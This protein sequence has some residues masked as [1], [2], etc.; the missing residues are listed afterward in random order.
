VVA[1]Q[2]VSIAIPASLVS[3]VPHLRE[4]TAKIGTIG[5]AAGIFGVEEII[6]YP[7]ANFDRQ[8]CEISLIVM[9][10]SYLETPQ[11]LRKRLFKIKPELR[12]VGVLP[13][14]RSQHH[15]LASHLKDLKDGEIRDGVVTSTRKNG[16]FVDVGVKQHAFI[17]H[18]RLPIGRRVTV[19]LKKG[20]GRLEGMVMKRKEIPVHWGYRVKPSKLMLGKLLRDPNFDLVIGTSRLG[21][22]IQNIYSELEKRWRG[23]RR[24]LVV[25]GGP[26]H[27]LYNIAKREKMNLESIAD[28]IINVFP[29][30]KVETVR[31]EEAVLA[32]LGVLNLL[33]KS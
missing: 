33:T 2:K 19:K 8:Q 27:G 3:D 20:E 23:S 22:P 11:Y 18:A 30:Q 14:L 26:T 9:V 12:Y 29:N 1:D 15:P 13:P 24:V 16:V 17:H 25:F 5:R 28:F 7:D 31:T 10:L 6:V 32:T 21:N 4:K